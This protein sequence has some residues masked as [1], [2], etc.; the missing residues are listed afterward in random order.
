MNFH[1]IELNFVTLA[2]LKSS[3]VSPKNHIYWAN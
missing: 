3:N 2:Y 1:E